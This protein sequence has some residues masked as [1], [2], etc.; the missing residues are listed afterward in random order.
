MLAGV[1]VLAACPADETGEAAESDTDGGIVSIGD[2]EPQAETE[3]AI[4]VG[5]DGS[6]ESGPPDSSCGEAEFQLT[7]TP[8]RMMLVLDKSGSMVSNTWD[9]DLD[10]DTAEI[11]RWASLHATV[12]VVAAGFDGA[13]EFGALLYPSAG[14]TS[15]YDENACFLEGQPDVS[16]APNNA[17]AVLDSIPPA[18]ATDAI[19]GGT[20][21]A[22]AVELALE[23]L[24][25][26]GDAFP[27][28][29]LFVTDGEANCTAGADD[30][31][32]L[33][34]VYDETL[35]DVVDAAWIDEAIPTYVVG[36]A[37]RD[38]VIPDAIDGTPDGINPHEMLELLADQGGRP[39]DGGG[40]RYYDTNSQIDLEDAL[41]EIV[42]SEF[43]C[44]IELDP[45][46][47][48]PAF[49]EIMIGDTVLERID[50]CASE[51]G[52]TFVNPDGPYD[53]VQLCGAAC[54]D[55]AAVGT[56]QAFYGCPPA[57]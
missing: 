6:E 26:L 21:S 17:Q 5:S 4:T 43:S 23:E 56:V 12:D 13:I 25:S 48:H 7:A 27:R 51:D 2:S 37:I 31:V 40:A 18:D 34:E 22:T 41:N 1:L 44:A 19:K 50:D 9:H 47:E 14:A 54:T 39:R 46:P 8:V 35:H 16:V 53:A 52:W 15:D 42:G 33:F 57:Q 49:V 20:P 36:I 30:V 24:R 38:E 29:L 55:L 10:P 3:P 11:T 32:Q 28:A 45:Q